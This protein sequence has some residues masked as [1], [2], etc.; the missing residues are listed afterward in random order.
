VRTPFVRSRHVPT[1]VP[2]G[3]LATIT[4]DAAMV[5]AAR[6]GGSAF[7]SR[8]LGPDMIGRWALD[9]AGGKWRHDDIS[10]E[11]ARPGELALGMLTHYATG[12]A[13]TQAFLLLPRRKNRPP[14]LP[15]A[16]AYGIATA[17][18]PLLIMFPSMGYGWFGIRS[19]EAA[20]IIRIMILGHIAFGLGIGL[21]AQRVADRRPRAAREE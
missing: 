15:A 2:V 3:V 1:G 10:G 5:A 9:L 11:P 6:L 16:T 21:W 19:G 12:I 20:R 4:M 7:A 17:A 14:S 13:L 8:R 18:L